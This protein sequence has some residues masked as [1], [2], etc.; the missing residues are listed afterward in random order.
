MSIYDLTEESLLTHIGIHKFVTINSNG[1]TIGH[2]A[3]CIFKF[4]SDGDSIWMHNY[5]AMDSPI[6]G[7]FNILLDIDE[8]PDGGFVACGYG[9]EINN[10]NLK[11]GW[12]IRVDDNGCLTSDCVSSVKEIENI[13]DFF[14]YPN[15]SNEILNITNSNQISF[16]HIFQFDGKLVE[17]GN[18]FPINISEYSTGLY[19]LQINTKTNQVIKSYYLIMFQTLIVYITSYR[20]SGIYFFLNIQIS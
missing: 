3:G 10:G 16:Y 17:H 11:R 7:D 6:Y 18:T 9:D 5:Q 8:M 2:I 20:T 13:K 19:F 12:L 14:V 15:P 4:S 1:D